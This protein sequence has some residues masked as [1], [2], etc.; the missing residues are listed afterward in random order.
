MNEKEIDYNLLE[1]EKGNKRNG[2]Y[3]KN[4]IQD[5]ANRIER[6]YEENKYLKEDYKKHIDRI[7]EL[8][9]RIDKAIEKLKEH[10]QDL[11]YEPWSVYQIEGSI[12]FDLVNILK[13][14]DS[15]E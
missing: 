7:N 3:L 6:L 10:K 11:D 12:L 5:Q 1:V 8:T 9:N 2:I 15:N 13:G 4:H 14:S